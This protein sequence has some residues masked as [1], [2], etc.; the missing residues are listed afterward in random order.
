MATAYLS[1]GTN[2]GDRKSHLVQ[3]VA[4]L[5][6]RAGTIGALSSLY[7]TEP[8]GF[9]SDNRFLNIALQLETSRPPLELLAVTRL[10]EIEMGRVAKSQGG[11]YED[12][13][14]DID[15]LLYEGV[16]MQTDVLTLPHPHMHE[17]RF[18]LEP[19]AEIAPDLTHPLLQKTM[20]ELLEAI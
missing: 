13:V 6:E 14:I 10:I 19:M 12:R 17:R 5:A 11:V 9:Q 4:L 2:L 20:K 1:L 18:V 7:E 15:L 8:W 16:I 3:A